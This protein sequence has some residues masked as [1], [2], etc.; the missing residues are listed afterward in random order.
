[1][2]Y[3]KSVDGLV[4][5]NN[6]LTRGRA[7]EPYHARKATLTFE[8]CRRVRVEGNRVA[9]DVLGRNIVLAG[10]PPADLAVGPGQN[11]VR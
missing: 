4:F 5:S 2:L 3:A 8:A 10:T 6:R 11:W 9:D 7:F 1:V